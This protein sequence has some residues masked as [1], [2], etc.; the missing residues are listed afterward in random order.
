MPGVLTATKSDLT[1]RLVKQDQK[2][3]D[4]ERIQNYIIRSDFSPIKSIFV[5]FDPG[6]DL[7][8]LISY[9]KKQ[10]DDYIETLP[11]IHI[12]ATIWED[13]LSCVISIYPLVGAA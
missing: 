10:I 1:D 9:L 11:F 4:I 12:A 6:T 8:V 3:M 7:A 5:E 2:Y 13:S